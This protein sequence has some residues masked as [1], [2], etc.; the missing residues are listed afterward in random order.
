MEFGSGAERS[1]RWLGREVHDWAW[2]F[3]PTVASVF[4]VL[5][6]VTGFGYQRLQ[7]VLVLPAVCPEPEVCIAPE[8]WVRT[9]TVA[10]LTASGFVLVSWL[11]PRRMEMRSGRVLCA[12]VAG[13]GAFVAAGLYLAALLV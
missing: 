11:L 4:A 10:L 6:T 12:F 8:L 3:A 9:A 1:A 2:W 5:A 7:G 13:L